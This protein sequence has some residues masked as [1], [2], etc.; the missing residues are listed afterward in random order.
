MEF[1]LTL[2]CLIGIGCGLLVIIPAINRIGILEEKVSDLDR[3]LSEAEIQLA[4]ALRS[5][6][7][8]KRPQVRVVRIDAPREA[9]E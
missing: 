8:S 7:I 9:V 2:M 6:W 4:E 5:G 3:D 1:I